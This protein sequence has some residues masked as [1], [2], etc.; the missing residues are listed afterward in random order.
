M[1]HTVISALLIQI[2]DIHSLCVVQNTIDESV[3]QQLLVKLAGGSTD[4]DMSAREKNRAKRKARQL[5]KQS[6]KDS[7]ADPTKNW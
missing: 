7:T 2:Y 5:A 3:R 4:V 1:T 6:S